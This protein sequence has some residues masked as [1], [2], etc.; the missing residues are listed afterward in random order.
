MTVQFGG[1]DL[2]CASVLGLLQQIS[3]A[4]LKRLCHLIENIDSGS[5]FAA[6]ERAH[7]GPVDPSSMRQFLLRHARG[8]ARA[9]QIIRQDLSDRHPC[10]VQRL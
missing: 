10:E 1:G 7:I 2:R 4:R 8:L 5:K 9:P 6:F 3:G